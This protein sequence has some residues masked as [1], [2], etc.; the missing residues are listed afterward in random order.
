MASGPP[1]TAQRL[2]VPRSGG[3]RRLRGAGASAELR[4]CAGSLHVWIAAVFSVYSRCLP[5]IPG[6]CRLRA[7]KPAL[8]TADGGG[9]RWALRWVPASPWLAAD[10]A[11]SSHR[12]IRVRL[13][14]FCRSC[15][16]PALRG[17]LDAFLSSVVPMECCAIE[18]ESP[19]RQAGRPTRWRAA[20][21]VVG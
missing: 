6:V 9:G 18:N 5:C 1:V 13:G 14:G 21:S 11:C 12:G 3:N 17:P 15:Q 7:G 10:G 4:P 16:M 2:S 8:A 20:P 19:E